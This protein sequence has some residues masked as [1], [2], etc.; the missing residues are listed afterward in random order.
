MGEPGFLAF[1]ILTSPLAVL[2][3]M[4]W[5]AA[6]GEADDERRRAMMRRAADGLRL[7]YRTTGTEFGTIAGTIAGRAVSVELATRPRAGMKPSTRA[8]TRLQ[9]MGQGSWPADVLAGPRPLVLESYDAPYPPPPACPTGDPDFDADI[10]VRG[11]RESVLT[12]LDRP[13]RKLLRQWMLDDNAA[14]RDGG[15][16]AFVRQGAVV[17]DEPGFVSDPAQLRRLLGR[18]MAVADGLRC[19]SAEDRL[20]AGLAG[21]EISIKRGRLA[22]LVASHPGTTATLEACRACLSDGDAETRLLAASGLGA[23]GSPALAALARDPVL[24]AELRVGATDAWARI[25]QPPDAPALLPELLSSASPEIRIAAVRAAGRLQEPTMLPR[26]LERARGAAGSEAQAIASTL[27]AYPGPETEAALARLLHAGE[28]AVRIEAARTLA[29]IGTLA[30][31]EP[32]LPL[33]RGL[34][35]DAD[36][37]RAAREAI[38]AIRARLGSVDAGRLS[39]SDLAAAA[40]ALSAAQDDRGALSPADDEGPA[41]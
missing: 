1:M 20:A 32:L 27:R 4:R 15:G 39:L 17:L 41:R 26:I 37:K 13:T 11:E 33:A 12:L 29:V 38:Q 8:V 18:L 36:V 6:N 10:E 40:G 28:A 7:Q 25:A 23:E 31:V 9:V 19:G 35:V 21:E 14:A 24:P 3:F 30:S 5:R 16:G 34:L 2:F 22:L